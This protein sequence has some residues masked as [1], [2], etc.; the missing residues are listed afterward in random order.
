M[1]ASLR[2]LALS[3]PAIALGL[4]AAFAGGGLATGI[5][6]HEAIVDDFDYTTI[7]WALI[8]PTWGTLAALLLLTRVWPMAGAVFLGWL[9]VV[10]GIYYSDVWG[11]LPGAFLLL[12]AFAIVLLPE[13]AA[14]DEDAELVET[15]E[16][17]V[18]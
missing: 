5:M 16:G 14:D 17:E 8:A 18:S 11:Y 9:A 1:A 15:A 6:A 13:S 7:S 2:R 12:L 3:W 4:F 10:T